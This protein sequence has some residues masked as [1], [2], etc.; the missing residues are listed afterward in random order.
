[1]REANEH[2][3]HV[4]TRQN[5]N[6]LGDVGLDRLED[7]IERGGEL[8]LSLASHTLLSCLILNVVERAH[9]VAL[10]RDGKVREVL[11]KASDKKLNH[12]A[13]G[14]LR[15]LETLQNL[16]QERRTSMQLIL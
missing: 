10:I 15:V 11:G 16:K 14:V 6:V 5:V 9:K 12:L 2:I 8:K 3:D 1:M 4:F 7:Q 13:S